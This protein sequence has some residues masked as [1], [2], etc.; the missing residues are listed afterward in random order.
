MPHAPAF[1]NPARLAL[2]SAL[3]LALAHL[4]TTACADAGSDADA[5]AL[6]AVPTFDG[7][8][9]LEFGEIDG[10]DPYLFTR[11]GS[12]AEDTRG[13]LIVADMQSYEI[14][15]FDPEGRFL[16]RFG[17]PGEGP[18]E[19]T[20]PCCLAFGPDGALWV[21]EST[22]YSAFELGEPGAEYVGG[23]QIAHFSQGMV[24]PVTFDAEGRLVDIG[25]SNTPEGESVM[26]RFH[27]GADGVTNEV[28]MA[29]PARQATGSTTVDRTFGEMAVTM[30]VY[31]PLGPTWI[32]AHGRGGSWAEAVTSEYVVNLHHADGTASRIEGP[33]L[34]GAELS[35]DEQDWAQ[36]RIDRDLQRLD[37]DQHPFPIPDRKPPL[38]A[39]YFDQSGRLWVEKT[40]AAGNQL[41]EADVYEG[42]TLVA[43]YRWPRRVRPGDVP[44][45]SESL[46]YGTTTDSLDVQRVAR[47]RFRPVG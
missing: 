8:V 6:D 30:Y 21:R 18:G 24:A 29:D 45:A 37:L 17:G 7:T 13:R 9:D 23:Q 22:R 12:I 19:L 46:L 32:H 14:R 34:P 1:S 35:P 3:A 28:P 40:G 41:R 31:Q 16:F 26:T 2:A 15:V 11:I 4:A 44:W 5:G 10:D 25:S 20:S 36:D 27:V 38:G 47:V 33:A 39:I 42:N 43:R